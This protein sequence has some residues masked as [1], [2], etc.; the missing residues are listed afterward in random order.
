M[1]IRLKNNLIKALKIIIV[2]AIILFIGRLF[3]RNINELKDI[4]FKFDLLNLILAVVL[5]IVYKINSV[6]LWHYITKKNECSISIRKAFVSW[7]Y[8]LLG[9]Y[10]PGKVFMLG[11]RIYFY[12]REGSSKKKVLFCFLVENICTVL[13]AA[14]LFIMSM[15]FV[16]NPDLIQYRY[17]AIGLIAVFFIIIHPVVL[18]RIINILLKILKKKQIELRMKYINMLGLV[19]VYSLNFLIVGSGFY[20]LTNSIYPV[21][22]SRFFYISGIFGLAAV[23][24]ILALFAPSG[25]GVREGVI[26]LALR[27]VIPEAAAI[28]VSIVSRLWATATELLLIGI[29]YIYARINKIRFE[30]EEQKEDKT[31]KDI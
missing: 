12:N 21:D 3:Y 18:T 30:T 31:S 10:I 1:D 9:K 22:I 17:P 24:G 27:Y 25:I 8:S 28:V 13:G 11:S 19:F 2:L 6:F 29:V 7:F 14:L 23:I 26:I 20:M 4:D 16:N 15:L 5:F